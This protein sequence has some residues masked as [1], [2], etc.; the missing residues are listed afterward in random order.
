MICV[1]KWDWLP[2]E[3]EGFNG[4]DERTIT[5]FIDEIARELDEHKGEDNIVG[6]YT[7]KQFEDTFNQDLTKALNTSD[8][9]IKIF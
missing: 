8:Y 6:I 9:W 3:W 5:A 4:F 7:N 1:G 2:A